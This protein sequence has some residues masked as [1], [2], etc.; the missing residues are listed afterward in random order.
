[1]LPTGYQGPVLMPDPE[2]RADS[3][4]VHT[5]D[6]PEVHWAE[7]VSG[8]DRLQDGKYQEKQQDADTRD[9]V[10]HALVMVVDV[11]NALVVH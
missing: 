8:D 7:D 9:D 2:R 5:E 10:L 1:M 3:H 4:R 11:G 6:D